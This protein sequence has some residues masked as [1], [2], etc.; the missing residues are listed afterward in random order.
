MR[1]DVHQDV[2][3]RWDGDADG[4]LDFVTDGVSLSHGHVR[5][6]FE[7]QI[8]Q[9][10]QPALA[11]QHFFDARHIWYG[12]RRA[13]VV[14]RIDQGECRMLCV[15]KTSYMRYDHYNNLIEYVKNSEKPHA[16]FI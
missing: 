10:V 5:I 3:H 6:D 13:E 7:V 12:D 2:L 14:A 9:V 1:L 8:H 4:V 15:G 16:D 11:S